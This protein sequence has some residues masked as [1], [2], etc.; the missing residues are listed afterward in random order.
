[1]SCTGNGMSFTNRRKCFFSTNMQKQLPEVFCSKRCSY[2]FRKMHK[3]IRVF[4]F[5]KKETRYR[6]FPVNLANFLRTPFLPSTSGR[7]LL[8]MYLKCFGFSGKPRKNKN[9]RVYSYVFLWYHWNKLLI[10]NWGALISFFL[11]SFFC[12]KSKKFLFNFYFRSPFWLAKTR[13]D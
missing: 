6:C 1:M 11:V 12:L 7:L 10:T 8:N 9:H 2:K 5:I 4:N 13:G 3:K